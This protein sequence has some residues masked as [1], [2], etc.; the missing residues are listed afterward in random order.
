[1]K[2]YD[3]NLKNMRIALKGHSLIYY[4]NRWVD[5]FVS[6]ENFFVDVTMKDCGAIV[7]KLSVCHSSQYRGV[8]G[9]VH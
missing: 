1:M 2:N 4:K 5:D 9:D 6:S 8:V 3:T 7:V